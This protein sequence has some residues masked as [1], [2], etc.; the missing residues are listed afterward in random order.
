MQCGRELRR[1]VERTPEALS[2]ETQGVDLWRWGGSSIAWTTRLEAVNSAL[3]FSEGEGFVT[4]RGKAG[5]DGRD[6]RSTASKR[7]V[8]DDCHC[9]VAWA[10]VPR[11]QKFLGF[12]VDTGA[13]I[14][15]AVHCNGVPI[16]A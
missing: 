6:R 14:G 11:A 1:V 13:Y 9:L 5:Q 2:K 10:A 15:T 4:S 12:L 7:G 8:L 16:Q 3:L